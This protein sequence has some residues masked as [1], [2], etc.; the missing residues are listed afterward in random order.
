[1][2]RSKEGRTRSGLFLGRRKKRISFETTFVVL[3]RGRMGLS[4][5]IVANDFA[6]YFRRPTT[7]AFYGPSVNAAYRESYVYVGRQAGRQASRQAGGQARSSRRR[8]VLC[9][10]EGKSMRGSGARTFLCL[11]RP[12]Q[13]REVPVAVARSRAIDPETIRH[14]R[15]T[16]SPAIVLLTLYGSP[17]CRAQQTASWSDLFRSDAHRDLAA[18]QP[19][20]LRSFRKK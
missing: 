16:R 18:P 13:D 5:S 14:S 15:A 9:G 12:A 17:V 1:M 8:R 4:N 7:W 11:Y 10:R 20:R 3:L 2:G 6:E 19:T